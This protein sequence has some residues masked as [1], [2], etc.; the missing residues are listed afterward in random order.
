MLSSKLSVGVH[1]LT[2]LAW[3]PGAAWTSE[4]LAR[5][6]NTHPVVIRRLL[7]LL[8]EAA[9]VESK[10]GAGGGWLLKADPSAITLL[11]I[12]RAVEPQNEAFGLHR[13]EPDPRCQVGC[14][15]QG[16]LC[17]VY[18]EV[19]EVIAGR[20]ASWTIAGIIAKVKERT[21]APTPSPP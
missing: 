1:L 8:R 11:K 21:P 3:E 18:G 17:E 16:V 14:N 7:G 13:S 19:Q 9:L 4:L 15:I 10:P 12:L 6:V 2:I 20:L 5:S